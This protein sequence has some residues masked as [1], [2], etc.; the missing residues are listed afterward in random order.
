MVSRKISFYNDTSCRTAT[1]SII[2]GKLNLPC[3]NDIVVNAVPPDSYERTWV[4]LY[5]TSHFRLPTVHCLANKMTPVT[6][7]FVCFYFHVSIN[8]AVD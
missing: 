4:H 1:Y 2:Q 6:D 8:V 3:Q 5:P 7:F